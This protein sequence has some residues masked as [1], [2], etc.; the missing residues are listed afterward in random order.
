MN[1]SDPQFWAMVALYFLVLWL[2]TWRDSS[3]WYRAWREEMHRAVRAESITTNT[4][5]MIDQLK[6]DQKETLLRL[7]GA[8][9]MIGEECDP[10]EDDQTEAEEFIRLMESR[11]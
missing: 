8:T 4:R 9:Q 3:A 2:I 6:R 1:F 7:K 11:L 5:G 10:D